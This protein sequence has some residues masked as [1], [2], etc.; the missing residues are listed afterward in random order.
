[1]IGT[2]FFYGDGKRKCRGWYTIEGD[3][4]TVRSAY[5]T[6]TAQLGGHA[7]T[8]EV[9]ARILLRELVGRARKGGVA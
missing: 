6:R 9:M 4:I 2:E 7:D 1:M 5:G 8:P 3:L